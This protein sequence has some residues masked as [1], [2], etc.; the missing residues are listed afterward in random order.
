MHIRQSLRLGFTVM[1]LFGAAA[2]H[3]QSYRSSVNDGN[4]AYRQQQYDAALKRY[5][6]ASKKDGER[7]ES[8]F[9]SGNV[10]YRN[11]DV[12]SA[13]KSYEEAGKRAASKEQ[14]AATLFNAGNVFLDAAEKGG[15]NP[16]L[17]QAGNNDAQA[18]RMEGYKQ[19]IE[20]YKKTLKLQ[21][22]DADA[23]YNLTYARKKLE[24]LQQQQKQNQNQDQKQ[25][26]QQKQDKQQDQQKQDKSKQEEQQKQDKNKLYSLHAPEVECISKGK[27]H[28]KYEFGVK[29]SVA[30]TNRDNFVVGMLAEPGNPYD[31]HTL[32]RAIE[33]VQR[34][35]G[36]TV[37]RSFVDRG[38]RGHDVKNHQVLISGRR[39]GMTLQMKKELKRRSAVEPVIGHMKTD[40]KLGRNYLLGALG[41]TINALLCGAGHNIRLI[42]KKLRKNLLLLFAELLLTLWCCSEGLKKS[43]AAPTLAN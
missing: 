4:E 27:A 12:K 41:D 39:R 30:T 23:R 36:C 33:Q 21:P 20:L 26:Q 2:L 35:T 5:N 37:Q 18:L 6:Q 32:A 38:Y 15:D 19:A 31:G 1:L 40:G 16:M 25:Q 43:V 14:L 28:K 22:T 13:L 9:N 42:L 24:E 3:A 8:R 17:Q 29:V 34:I 10:H 11:G 7:M